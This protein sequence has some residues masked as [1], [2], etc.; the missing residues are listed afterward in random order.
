MMDYTG[1][2]LSAQDFFF[3]EEFMLIQLTGK[4]M[5]LTTVYATMKRERIFHVLTFLSFK[6][7][8]LHLINSICHC[9]V[10]FVFLPECHFNDLIPFPRYLFFTDQGTRGVER[11]NLDG[12]NR[13]VISNEDV[14]W[15]NQI[16]VDYKTQWVSID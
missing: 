4:N 11:T 10:N 14:Y 7:R 15:P 1:G 5:L 8:L 12:S 6:Y 9:H 13:R 2:L 16:T 3:P